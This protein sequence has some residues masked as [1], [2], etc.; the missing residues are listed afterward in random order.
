ML[1][2]NYN[3]LRRR[4]AAITYT[5]NLKRMTMKTP[6]PILLIS[7]LSL[8]AA[9]AANT[10]P[11]GV[12]AATLAPSP[13][14]VERVF[15]P[16]SFPL[17]RPAVFTGTVT[18]VSGSTV[19]LG[20][21]ALGDLLSVPHLLHVKSATTAKATGRSFLIT[22][23]T[24]T[25]VAVDTP[26]LTLSSLLATGDNVSISPAHTLGSVFGA[27]DASVKLKKGETAMG[28]DVVYFW[29]N[30]GWSAYYYYPDYGWILDT[31]P[32]NNLQTNAVLF[33]DE[34]VLVGRISQNVLPADY[35]V[36]LGAVPANTQTV[37]VVAPGLTLLSNPL[38][39]ACTIAQF[40]FI[41]S[42]GWTTG[43]TAMSADNV[44]LWENN[45]WKTYYYY[46]DYGWIRDDDPDNNLQ[47]DHPIP[48][49]S[50]FL[51]R[52]RGAMTPANSYIQTTLNYSLN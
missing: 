37:T 5:W 28:A 17:S 42:P 6:L 34:G 13:N 2:F 30:Q 50:A 31:D 24:A 20:G 48:S 51:I 27:D 25:S 36:T 44:Y 45:G 21:A 15:T 16:V 41:G 8:A 52:R 9:Q 47:D 10:D 40:G 1:I 29:S 46:P 35:L 14:G 12:M 11:V 18:M 26:G 49:G 3:S 22:V 23:A 43:E 39:T 19:Q 38:P 33:P 32:D 7:W 4:Q